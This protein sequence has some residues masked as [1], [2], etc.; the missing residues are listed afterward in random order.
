[1]LNLVDHG[2]QA[3]LACLEILGLIL[4]ADFNLTLQILDLVVHLVIDAVLQI[5]DQLEHPGVL[6]TFAARASGSLAV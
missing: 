3:V 1:M 5:L 4:A 2:Y 6:G